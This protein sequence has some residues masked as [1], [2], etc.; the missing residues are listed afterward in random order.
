MFA[1]RGLAL[2]WERRTLPEP[3]ADDLETVVRSKLGALPADRGTWI[4]DD[5]GLFLSALGG[6]PGVYSAYALRTI[7]LD[8]L[9]RL[10]RG[11]GREA[12][13]RTV[14]GV[15]QGAT[16]RLFR[17]EV[18]GRIAMRARGR[19]GFGYD[20]IF[21]PDGWRR[22]FG[23]VPPVEKNEVSHRARAMRR[24]ATYLSGRAGSRKSRATKE[25]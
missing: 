8:G 25:R 15:R 9:L 17:G 13:F 24:A 22:T 18:R 4:V 11:R 23:Q 19:H 12:V 7:G 2:G 14:A 16:S 3:Q 20:P 6:F 10:L 21:I 1:A 5:S